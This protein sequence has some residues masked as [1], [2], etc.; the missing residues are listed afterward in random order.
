MGIRLDMPARRGNEA[1]LDV[2]KQ[3]GKYIGMGVINLLNC[4]NP[5]TVVFTG[6]LTKMGNML[7]DLIKIEIQSKTYL[8]VIEDVRIEFGNLADMA[9]VVGAAGLFYSKE[10]SFSG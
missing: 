6:G 3:T 4:F 9:G 10:A 1:A 7:L 5:D 8:E 2:I